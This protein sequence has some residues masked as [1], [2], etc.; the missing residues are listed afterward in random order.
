MSSDFL[1]RTSRALGD[2]L[3]SELQQHKFCVVGC[4]GTGAL[5]A[6]MLV[7]TGAQKI[8][9]IDGDNV[10]ESNLN[11]VISFVH[12]DVDKPKVDVLKSRLESV[13]S[14]ITVK[15]ISCHFREYDPNDSNGQEARD[16]ICNSDVIVIAVDKNK[17]RIMCE[18]LCY[19]DDLHK[20]VIGIGVYVNDTGSAGYECSWCLRTPDSK[21]DEEGYGIGSYASI[22]IEATAVAFSM[23]L[24]NLKNPVSSDF[25]YFF[26]SYKNFVPQ[27]ICG[28]QFNH[29]SRQ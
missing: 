3:I 25:N 15:A 29:L 4:G 22:V 13:N 12:E 20:K 17:D 7:R 27:E 23:L 26:K 8:T 1:S 9:L 21:K 16:A 10:D 5:F 11:R 2:K 28:V 24:H 19:S 14:S 6:E 18:K